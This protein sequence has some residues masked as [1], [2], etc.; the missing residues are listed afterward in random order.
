MAVMPAPDVD[1]A[2][3]G[4]PPG[5]VSVGLGKGGG[6]QRGAGADVG[7]TGGADDLNV[8]IG[9]GVGVGVGLGLEDGESTIGAASE[10]EVVTDGGGWLGDGASAL[11][12]ATVHPPAASRMATQAVAIRFVNEALPR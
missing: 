3:G 2:V 10:T 12:R 7:R 8:G 6:D 4:R 9:L 11:D 1:P 5:A